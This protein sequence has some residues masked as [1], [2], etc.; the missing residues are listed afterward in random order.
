[1]A[2]AAARTGT[3]LE[4]NAQPRRLDL[5]AQMARRALAAGARIVIGADAHSGEALDLIRFGVL[6]AR[7][8]GARPADVA[9]TSDWPDLAAAR[10]ARRAAAGV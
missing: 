3:L 4:V 10:A 2:A 5:D 9:N 6:V 7:R 8:A 1:V